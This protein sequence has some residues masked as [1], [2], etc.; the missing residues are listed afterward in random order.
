MLELDE[1][2]LRRDDPRH[3]F[4]GGRSALAMRMGDT[5][6]PVFSPI[7]Q[8]ASAGGTGTAHVDAAAVVEEAAG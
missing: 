7:I 2:V 1:E 6:A 3:T 8:M 4:N 5:I